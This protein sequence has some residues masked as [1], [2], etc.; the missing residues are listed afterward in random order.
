M[1]IQRHEFD[2]AQRLIKRDDLWDVQSLAATVTLPA[3]ASVIAPAQSP[4]TF[5]DVDASSAP[6]TVRLPPL[7]DVPVGAELMW[8]KTDSSS[9]AVTVDGYEAET[10]DGA[11]T[12]STA[13]QHAKLHLVRLSSEWSLLE[14]SNN[15]TYTP[16]VT[17]ISNVDSVSSVQVHSWVRIGGILVV[18]G[19]F[20]VDHTATGTPTIVDISLPTTGVSVPTF[21]AVH[22]ASGIGSSDGSGN[23]GGIIQAKATSKLLRYTYRGVGTQNETQ[24]VVAHVKL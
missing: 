12:K 9:N 11:T 22:E 15:G 14:S 8:R 16:V 17:G 5:V 23:R 2:Q 13:T 19:Q 10:I 24:A 18:A 3:V 6:V 4:R 1:T 7:E 20:D 21:S